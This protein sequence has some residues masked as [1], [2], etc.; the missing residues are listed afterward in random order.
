MTALTVGFV[1]E[2][3]STPIRF[4]LDKGFFAGQGLDVKLV[5]FPSGSGH[6]IQCLGDGLIDIAVGLTEAFVAGTAKGNTSYKTIGTYVDSPLCW[7]IST[8]AK[9]DELLL[10][11]QLA[12]KRI[13]VLR[14][15]L[16]LYVMLFVLGLQRQFAPPFFADFT[17][18]HTFKNLRDLVNLV[19]GVDGGVSDAF[20][21]E[22]FTSKR[23]YDLGEIKQI[24][25]IYTP[26]PLWV[27]TAR[28][29]LVA[30]Q[31]DALKGFVEA[32][33]QGVAYF[34]LHQNEA[35]EYIYTHLDYSEEDARAWLKTVRFSSNPGL[36][37]WDRVVTK[38][39]EVLTT[40]GVLTD[41]KATIDARLQEGVVG[42]FV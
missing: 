30:T 13:G 5:P 18:N 34:E 26:W 19:D 15:G 16:G 25:E 42:L 12:G 28:L 32:V 21:W 31:L 14:I 33:R 38:T 27:V 1:P 35:A 36:V 9:R 41:D 23:Y 39:A 10:A 22:Y 4:A 24:G 11:E 3:F 8:G 7:A 37:D 40:A 20:M 29:E 2:H 17:I 6:L